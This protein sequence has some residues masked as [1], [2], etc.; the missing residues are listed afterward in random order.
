MNSINTRALYIFQQKK[1]IE[2]RNSKIKNYKEY[3]KAN[4]VYANE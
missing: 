3:Q 2:E 1:C 4:K